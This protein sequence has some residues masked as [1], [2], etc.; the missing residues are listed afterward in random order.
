MPIMLDN[1]EL[2]DRI[3]REIAAARVDNKIG[4]T[5]DL[6]RAALVAAGKIEEPGVTTFLVSKILGISI[7]TVGRHMTALHRD[8]EIRRGHTIE[9]RGIHDQVVYE[10]TFYIEG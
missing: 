10:H 5:K 7:D 9:R 6:V 3:H 1:Q 2:V 4:G 8:G